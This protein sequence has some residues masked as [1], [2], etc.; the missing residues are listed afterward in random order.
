MRELCYFDRA[1]YSYNSDVRFGYGDYFRY[2]KHVVY[3]VQFTVFRLN[4]TLSLEIR[5]VYTI[6]VY[7]Y[8]ILCMVCHSFFVLNSQF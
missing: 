1:R 8:A 7:N 3:D 6:H 2:F 5:T 4:L